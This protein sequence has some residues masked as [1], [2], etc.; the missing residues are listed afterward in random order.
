LLSSTDGAFIDDVETCCDVDYF[1]AD[2]KRHRVYVTCGAGLV[3]VFDENAGAYQRI[4]RVGTAPGARTGLFVPELDRLFV[5]VRAA[6]PEPAAIWV[7]R[8]PP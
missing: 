4:G 8:P 5:A 3:D 6:G 1:F 2:A 7:F